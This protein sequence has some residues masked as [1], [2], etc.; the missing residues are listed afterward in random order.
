MEP[1]ACTAEWTDGRLTVW[2]GT[3]TPFNVRAELAGVFG[4]DPLDGSFRWEHPMVFQPQGASS[5]PIAVGNK[6]VAS[7]QAHGAVAVQVGKK[8]DKTTAAPAWQNKELRS[9]FSSGVAAGDEVVTFDLP[10]Y[11]GPGEVMH[12]MS[13]LS[14]LDVDL[15]VAYLPL[16]PV[17]R[18]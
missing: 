5:T 11:H 16:M 14:P 7:T 17:R 15:A 13:F 1:H 18:A 4:L 9:Y 10:H 6:L 3:Q 2:T 8:E 12:L